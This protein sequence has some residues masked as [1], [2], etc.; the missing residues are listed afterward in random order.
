MSMSCQNKGKISEEDAGEMSNSD[1]ESDTGVSVA[2]AALFASSSSASGLVWK[3]SGSLMIPPRRSFHRPQGGGNDSSDSNNVTNVERL[4]KRN[5][6]RTMAIHGVETEP[7]QTAA[8]T[9]WSSASMTNLCRIRSSL[10]HSDPQLSSSSTNSFNTS[11]SSLHPQTKSSTTALSSFSTTSASRSPANRPSLHSS[12]SPVT[13]QRC[14]SPMRVPQ[15]ST[16]SSHNFGAGGAAASSS[17]SSVHSGA[18]TLRTYSTR[19]GSSL[20]APVQDTR[21]WS[22]ASL[23]STSGYGTPGTGSNSGVSSQYSSSEQIG[24]M[25]D[26]TR[27]SGP[28]RQN[29]SRFDSNDSYDDMASQQQAAA[30]NAFL[31]RPRSRSLTSPMK[32][33][34]EYNIEMVNRT[35][36]Y[37]ER[38]PRA[39]L[40]MEERLNAFVAENGPLSGGISQ[41]SGRDDID[42]TEDM[43]TQQ[44]GSSTGFKAKDS[45]EEAVMRSR[46]STVSHISTTETAMN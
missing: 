29:S 15:R 39:K 22:L 34:N 28:I 46:R 6:R 30:Q 35:S 7:G 27:I 5:R 44:S 3:G 23:P 19:N 33:L 37:K 17:G 16:S 36:V 2:G 9:G 18:I 20:M 42:K 31:N 32:F 12:T 14:R 43:V 45:V 4:L 11:T 8:S 21:R 40:Q 25:L 24:E 26:Q 38:F 10:G 1:S 41:Q 13:L